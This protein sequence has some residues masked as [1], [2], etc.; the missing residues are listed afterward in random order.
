MKDQDLLVN[1][2]S[3][4]LILWYNIVGDYMKKKV[5]LLLII[6]LMTGCGKEKVLKC[7]SIDKKDTA[8]VRTNQI[9]TFS[10]NGDKLTK[11][12]VEIEY[13]YSEEYMRLLSSFGSTLESKVDTESICEAYTVDKGVSCVTEVK[14]NVMKIKIKGNVDGDSKSYISGNYKDIKETYE[15]A[16]YTCK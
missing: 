14:D 8:E 7:S 5:L 1:S 10:D 16:N 12:N 11:F 4:F 13:I 2:K 6:I 15:K 3:F 9:F